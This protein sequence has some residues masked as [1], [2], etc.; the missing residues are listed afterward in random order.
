[1]DFLGWG[2]PASLAGGQASQPAF[3][4]LPLKLF[5]AEWGAH[6]RAAVEGSQA[7]AGFFL[8]PGLLEDHGAVVIPATDRVERKCRQKVENFRDWLAQSAAL[9]LS[10]S[11]GT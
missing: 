3:F 8:L 11:K 2:F 9:R 1:M 6:A 5:R 4:Q 7:G 10:S